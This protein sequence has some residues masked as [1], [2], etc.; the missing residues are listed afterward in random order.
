[1]KRLAMAVMAAVVL[2]GSMAAFAASGKQD[3]DLVNKTGLTIDEV[4][5]SP[6][7]TDDWEEDVLGVDTLANG[8]KVTITFDRD[9]TACKWD[10]KIVDEDGD[11][12]VWSNFD[13]CKAEEITLLYQGKKPTAIIK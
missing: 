9:E 3:F 8:A 13:L 2:A 1:M 5:V 12:V 10:L 6:A 11:S 4:Y 7:T